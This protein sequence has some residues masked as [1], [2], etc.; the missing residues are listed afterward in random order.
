MSGK[1]YLRPTGFLYGEAAAHAI[2]SGLALPL[3]GM[4]MAFSCA[5]IIEGTPLKSKRAMHLVRDIADSTDTNLQRLVGRIVAPRQPV[6]GLSLDR[7]RLM[8][9]VNITPDSFSDGGEHGDRTNA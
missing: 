2:K 6:A 4:P 5:E 7:V 1:L 8:G 9:I 3:A